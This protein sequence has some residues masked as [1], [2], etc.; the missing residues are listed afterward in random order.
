MA[1]DKEL[2]AKLELVKAIR[3]L[4]EESTICDKCNYEFKVKKTRRRKIGEHE[5]QSVREVY[6]NCPN[7]KCN[8]SYHVTLETKKTKAL[9][10]RM[11]R[12]MQM[13]RNRQNKDKE[14][15]IKGLQR[16]Y[17]DLQVKLRNEVNMLK[18]IFKLS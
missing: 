15:E 18:V 5:G 13:I 6:F 11:R 16:E 7:K 8:A 4:K 10:A 14:D 17:R 12:L 1:Y 2:Q 3:K 9:Q